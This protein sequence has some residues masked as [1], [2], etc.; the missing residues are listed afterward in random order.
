MS[1]VGY[2][3]KAY[4]DDQIGAIHECEVAPDEDHLVAANEIA[5][6]FGLGK[7]LAHNISGAYS[8]EDGEILTYFRLT[9][10]RQ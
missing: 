6:R 3:L 2:T 7:Y 5:S 4:R 1:E 9:P 10:L 8:Y